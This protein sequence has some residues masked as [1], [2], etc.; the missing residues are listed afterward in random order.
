MRPPA[1]QVTTETPIW[2]PAC[3]VEH[4]ASAFNRETRKFSGLSGICRDAQAAKRQTPKGKAETAKRNQVRW[5]QPEYRAKSKKWQRERRVRLG[6]SHDLR[7]SRARLQRIVDE[8]KKQGCVDCGY[9]DV[10]A[11][12]PDHLDGD[13]KAGHVSRLVTLCASADRIRAEL[14]KCVPRCARCH[15]RATQTQQPCAWRAADR[16]PPSWQRRLDR[17][18]LND[19]IKVLHGC[20]DCGW[21]EW[22]R[23]LDWDHVRGLKVA[24]IAGLIANGRP[25]AEVLAE[26]AKCEVVCA[27]C[28]RIRTQVRSTRG[29]RLS[30]DGQ[31]APSPT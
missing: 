31:G 28:H 2:C 16:L 14:A 7:R 25:W 11:I 6:S 12:D 8:W 24:G 18:D 21:N 23:G 1:A 22:A 15:R 26:M 10:R 20:T 5:S 27:N 29:I 4:P 19:L 13:L 17:Q 3:E 30:R 9:D